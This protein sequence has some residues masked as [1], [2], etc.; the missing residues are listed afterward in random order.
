MLSR[1]R[2]LVLGVYLLIAGFFAITIVVY[3]REVAVSQKSFILSSAGIISSQQTFDFTMS[4][5][6]LLGVSTPMRAYLSVDGLYTGAGTLVLRIDGDPNS[7]QTYVL[8]QATD[9]APLQ[10]VYGD[11]SGRLAHSSAGT[12]AHTLTFIPSGVVLSGASVHLTNSYTR[13]VGNNCPDG[14]P[15]TEKM[16]SVEFF[17]VQTPSLSGPTTFQMNYALNDNITGISNAVASAY[18]EMVGLYEGGGQ[19]KIYFN[20]PLVDG[21]TE[22]LPTSS[23]PAEFSLLSANVASVFQHTSAGS[24]SQNVTVDPGGATLSNVSLKLV[25][26]YRFHPAQSSCGGFPPTGDAQSA[27]LDTGTPSGV[28]YNSITWRGVLGGSS[29]D[30]GK[31]R[32]Q[33]ATAACSNGASDPPQCTVGTWNFIGGPTCSASDWFVTAG[34]DIPFDLFRS[35]C[36][37]ALNGKQYY[38]YKVQLC[39]DDCLISGQ[40]TP[41]ID[42]IFVSWSP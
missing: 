10:L 25:I 36:S 27:A 15:N 4:G 38:K 7:N 3:A 9:P 35:G 20:D 26:T 41:S 29:N 18:V 12:Y 32:F 40:T 28:L 11:R 23:G 42:E 33:L 21:I 34:P 5:G 24:F 8:P 17:I 19:A 2:Q 13:E 16:K 31:V 22:T 14:A 30:K 6:E 1:S 39:A 37:D